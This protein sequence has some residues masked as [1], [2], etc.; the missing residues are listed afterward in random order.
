MTDKTPS[1]IADVQDPLP[2]ANW[3]WRRVFCF[4]V[5]AVLLFFMWGAVDRIGKVAVVLPVQGIPALVTF[6]KWT[7]GFAG[8]VVTYYLLAPSAEQLTKL[9][10]TASLLKAGVQ[11]ASRTIQR[12]DKTETAS[13][14]GIPPVVAAPPVELP[15]PPVAPEPGIEPLEAP[16]EDTGVSAA[17]VDVSD[18]DPDQVRPFIGSYFVKD[19][20]R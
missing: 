3:L 17:P 7:I 14:V 13:T 2:E 8:L 15:G 12:P 10:K 5:T 19:Q 20:P 6:S 4:A 9:V 16:D 1:L 11:M 18:A